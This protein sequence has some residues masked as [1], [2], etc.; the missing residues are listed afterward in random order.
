MEEHFKKEMASIRAG[1]ANPGMIE[2]VLVDAYGAKTPLKQMASIAVPEPRMMIVE[3]WDK[4]LIKEVEKAL[5]YANLG[6]GVTAEKTL[7]RVVVP[8]MTE[9][10]RRDL[11][12]I[13]NEKLEMAKINGRAVREKVKEEIIAGFNDKKIRE[14]DKYNFIKELDDEVSAL[15][16]DL[17]GLAASKEKEIMSI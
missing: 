12:K 1:R 2:N 16:R 6:M 9:E 4:N 14:D 13:M 17:Q 5:A 11:V 3:P 15:N 7:V 10:N 8:Q